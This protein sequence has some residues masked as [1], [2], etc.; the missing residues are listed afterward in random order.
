MQMAAPMA[1]IC[2]SPG[3]GLVPVSRVPTTYVHGTTLQKGRLTQPLAHFLAECDL[4][5][6]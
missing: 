2:I 5:H 4:G 1:T 3:N 6:I